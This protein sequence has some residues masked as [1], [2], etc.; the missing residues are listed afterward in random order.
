[1]SITSIDSY[2]MIYDMILYRQD[3]GYTWFLIVKL[4]YIH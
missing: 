4:P 1:M 2:G 3:L